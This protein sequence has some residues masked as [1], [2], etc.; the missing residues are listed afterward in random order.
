MC[1]ARHKTL[2]RSSRRSDELVVLAEEKG[3]LYWVIGSIVGISSLMNGVV[4]SQ[5]VL[6]GQ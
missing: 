6:K 3:S 5:Q 4:S 2:E 1:T